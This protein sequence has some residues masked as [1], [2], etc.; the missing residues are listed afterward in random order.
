MPVAGQP[1]RTAALVVVL[2]AVFAGIAFFVPHGGAGQIA[3]AVGFIVSVVVALFVITRA[4]SAN[5][6]DRRQALDFST[7]LEGSIRES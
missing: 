6:S 3:A 5:I 2:A 7:I 1:W 4:S